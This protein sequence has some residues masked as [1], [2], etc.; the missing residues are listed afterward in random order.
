MAILDAAFKSEQQKGGRQFETQ[1]LNEFSKTI[2]AITAT[3]TSDIIDL[4]DRS[5]LRLD[6]DVSA[7]S[8]TTPTLDVTIQHSADGVTFATLGTFTQKTAV[9]AEHKV[10]GGCDRYVRALFTVGGTTPSFTKTLKGF[11]V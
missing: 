2:T 7:R 1:I 6:L 5:T 4:G 8:G 10:F 11:A 9:S 3:E